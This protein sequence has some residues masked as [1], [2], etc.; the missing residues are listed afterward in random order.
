MLPEIAQAA[1][2]L[3]RGG[4]VAFP[5]DTVWGLLA[6]WQNPEAVARMVAMKGRPREK[7][8][9]ILIQAPEVARRF[10]PEGYRNPRFARLAEAYWPGP[11]TLVVPARGVPPWISRTGTV[12]LRV[13]DHPDLRA[14]LA[15]AGGA[16]AA[17]S[18]NPA[19]GRPARTRTEAEAFGA[20]FVFPGPEP[21]GVA[22][23][24]VEVEPGRVLREGAIPA[25]DL[26]RLLEE[27][28]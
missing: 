13:P 1:R 22:S 4:V 6:D 2:T 18:L 15:A 17:T 25:A 27:P 8:V 7:P 26:Y 19:G 20:A 23:T 10:L 12:G 14:L 24:V 16:L 11:L 5:T 21:P 28:A 3:A 9:Q